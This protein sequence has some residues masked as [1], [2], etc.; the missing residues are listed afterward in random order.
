MGERRKQTQ[1]AAKGHGR[2]VGEEKQRSAL[3][4]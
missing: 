2:A 1:E 4:V 3:R